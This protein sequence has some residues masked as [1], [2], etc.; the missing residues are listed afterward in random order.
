MSVKTGGVGEKSE[1][2]I[3]REKHALVQ[4]NREMIS[5]QTAVLSQKVG[6]DKIMDRCWTTMKTRSY[7][8]TLFYF[9]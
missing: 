8:S 3:T 6:R 4:L 9:E 2:S 5:L 7:S 1:Q